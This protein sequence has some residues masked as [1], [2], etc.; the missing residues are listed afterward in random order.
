MTNKINKQLLK[1]TEW[2][3]DALLPKY[4]SAAHNAF[5]KS[6]SVL[7]DKI[8]AQRSLLT[9]S[10]TIPQFKSLM[11]EMEQL[12]FML[13]K[14]SAHASFNYSKNV[15]DTA[16]KSYVAFVEEFGADISNRLLY[17]EQWYIKLPETKARQ[18]ADSLGD[19]AHSFHEKYDHG[20]HV[21]SE[22]EEKIINLKDITGASAHIKFYDSIVSGWSFDYDGKKQSLSQLSKYLQSAD[23][24]KR[25]EADALIEAKFKEYE[26]LLG[27]IYVALTKDYDIEEVKLRKYESPLAVRAKSE[28]ISIAAINSLF[29]A[30]KSQQ[31]VFHDFFALKAKLMSQKKLESYDL[32]APLSKTKTEKIPYPQAM[33][34]VLSAIEHISPRFL[35]LVEKM[36]A[37]HHV[38]SVFHKNKQR[39]AYNCGLPNGIMPYVFMQYLG[40]R[41]DMFTIMHELGHSVHSMHMNKYSS[42]T[43]GAPI[44]ICE[45]VSTFFE[46]IL[47]EQELQTA[48]A[49]KKKELLAWK[50]TDLF[51][52]VSNGAFVSNF[53]VVAHNLVSA[54]ATHQDLSA[55][56]TKLKKEQLGA[57]VKT[58]PH[59][60]GWMGIP[61]IYEM[62]FYYYN[63]A[64]GN[65]IALLFLQQF[66][67]DPVGFRARFEKYLSVGGTLGTV[68]TLK[69]MG[70]DVE[71][72]KTWET[73]FVLI[74]DRVA[75][76]KSLL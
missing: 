59:L 69:V 17:F 46:E 19:D 36:I 73:A 6:I 16:A 68:E 12:S 48:S 20:K 43:S 38:D 25:K 40:E 39:G 33:R 52:S 70:I 11:K 14:L 75:Q 5:V 41:T 49:V 64:I 28:E 27:D 30:V 44:G 56:W 58:R 22:A 26:D 66:K 60:I 1:Q 51:G 34:N 29:A 21:L 37:A 63:Y 45:S 23:R 62:P 2:D 10:I 55:Q 72:K 35:S 61:H 47:F 54:G 15:K 42:F 50:L 74:N 67:K 32:N 53:E 31:K 13:S 7:V 9:S 18:L 57:A 76:L 65:L 24:K 71:D 8:V 4:K 3:L